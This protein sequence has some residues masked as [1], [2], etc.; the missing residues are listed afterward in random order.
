MKSEDPHHRQYILPLNY[1]VFQISIFYIH[2]I[3]L[4]KATFPSDPAQLNDFR[5]FFFSAEML[6]EFLVSHI[7]VPCAAPFIFFPSFC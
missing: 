6:K 7:R 2:A 5:F 4:I 3:Y 1:T